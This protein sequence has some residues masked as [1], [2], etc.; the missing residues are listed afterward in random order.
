MFKFMAVPTDGLFPQAQFSVWKFSRLNFCMSLGKEL[1]IG[2][3][4]ALRLCQLK[5]LPNKCK[6]FPISHNF[7]RSLNGSFW[8]PI[9]KRGF[10]ESGSRGRPANRRPPT[11]SQCL[12]IQSL[13]QS[14]HLFAGENRPL[15]V[16]HWQA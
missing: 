14:E 7:G 3:L 11:T 6:V 9:L 8:A 16:K 12:S 1:T 4:H 15:Y 2:E 10:G 13:A 5:V